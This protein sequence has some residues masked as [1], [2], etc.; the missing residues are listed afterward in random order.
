MYCCSSV[1]FEVVQRNEI[2]F[3]HRQKQP[4]ALKYLLIFIKIEGSKMDRNTTMTTPELGPLDLIG[5]LRGQK[6]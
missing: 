4:T 2:V 6:V 1:Q 5:V 3:S